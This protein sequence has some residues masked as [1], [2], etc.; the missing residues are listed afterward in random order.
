MSQSTEDTGHRGF[1]LA[2]SDVEVAGTDEGAWI[3]IS[4]SSFTVRG[5]G[6]HRLIRDLVAGCDGRATVQDVL[7]LRLGPP[8]VR[9]PGGP[10]GKG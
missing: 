9:E 8:S 3:G 7:V 1:V 10:G 4:D 6:A 5:N 2:R